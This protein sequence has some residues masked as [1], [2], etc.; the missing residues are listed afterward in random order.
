MKRWAAGLGC[1]ML[2][3]LTS[4]TT[5]NGAG[6]QGGAGS[7]SDSA[8]SGDSSSVASSSGT[9]GGSAASS[10]G[11]GGESATSSS[12]SGAGGGCSPVDVHNPCTADQ[13][14]TG[15]PVSTPVANGTACADVDLC[16]QNDTCQSG[17]CVGGSPV[18]CAAGQS[19]FGGACVAA[20]LGTFGVPETP[21]SSAGHTPQAMVSA[22]LNGDGELDLV[23]VNNDLSGNSVSVLL[24]LGNGTFAAATDY[25]TGSW[26][27][28]VATGDLNG[29]G[30]FD[31][32]VTIG[33]S[34]FGNP[35]K[36][37]LN[38]GN[39]T[40][41][42]AIDY[43]AGANPHSVAVGDLNG[44]GKPDL[45][46][47][48][49]GNYDSNTGVTSLADISVL[50]NLGNGSFAAPV[51]Y[52]PGF[53]PRAL[54]IADLNGDGKLDIGFE[55]NVDSDVRVLFNQGNG[56][57]GAAVFYAMNGL[58]GGTWGPGPVVAADLNGDGKLD[59]AAANHS[60]TTL[61][62]GV[63]VLINQGNGVFAAAAWYGN[64]NGDA[65]S[66]IAVDLNGDGKLDL[67][68]ATPSAVGVRL[69]L[70]NGTFSAEISHDAGAGAQSV[71]AVDLNG[72]GKPELAVASSVDD[73]FRVLVNH[74]NGTFEAPIDHDWVD[75]L[76]SVIATADL[77]GDGTPD[78]A[79]AG[80]DWFIATLSVRLNNGDGTFGV[81]VD[82]SLGKT[83][84]SIVARDLNGDGAADLVV[85]KNNNNGIIDADD[86]VAVLLN[87]GNGTF[88]AQV[89]YAAGVG[90]ESVAV[91]DVDGDGKL[92]LVVASEA[93]SSVNVLLN[94]GNGTF[95]AAIA[96]P[97]GLYPWSVV[98]LDLNGDGHPDLAVANQGSDDVSVLQNQG[99][100]TFGAA[101]TY[102]VGSIP[103]SIVAA[104]LDGDGHPDLAV[105][106]QGSASVS[107]LQN[108]GNGLF[109]P[110][111]S[112]AVGAGSMSVV[113]ADLDSDGR[114]D[115]A[116]ASENSSSVSVLLNLGNGTFAT[117]VSRHVASG[118]RVV[119][120]VDMNG[121]GTPE[122]LVGSHLN[123]TVLSS[124]CS[125]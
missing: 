72:D 77:N 68:T 21:A 43:P 66:L 28:S 112:Y 17:A 89:D 110:G 74:G 93:D 30:W 123:M 35:V 39:G 116:V 24:N 106:N 8:S 44:D 104:D 5:G 33:P 22:D 113:A 64:S 52:A 96:Y 54:L 15:V 37:F 101:V 109:A 95:G 79:I 65:G 59:I 26:A 16:T 100:G 85:V 76:P 69:N 49:A 7:T 111:V 53:G 36:V 48:N 90:P 47:G 67:A 98:A 51:S 29:D 84:T 121:D 119:A 25:A 38:Q 46:V 45:A 60:S 27:T 105:V 94:Q 117:A 63:S 40:F 82:Y 120:A 87:Q 78:L 88:G 31:L 23:L 13:G 3:T 97:A 18:V 57:F 103:W 12:S 124:T 80:Y 70:G 108:Q 6:G 11:T 73:E 34:P 122:L 114:M 32:A 20:C 4:C 86:D 91:A 125:P 58:A 83:V 102:A 71:A 99:N 1:T 107:V 115:L 50:F 42:A 81:G 61:D 2:V 14:V 41:A 56:T 19:C 9:G 75:F 55:Y 92:D 10:S 118:P 62:P